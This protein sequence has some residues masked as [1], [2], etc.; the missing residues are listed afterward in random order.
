MKET[1]TF[2]RHLKIHFALFIFMLVLISLIVI[3]RVGANVPGSPKTR[4]AYS[5]QTIQ[6]ISL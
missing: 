1:N 4:T 2:H 3:K 5:H 6:T